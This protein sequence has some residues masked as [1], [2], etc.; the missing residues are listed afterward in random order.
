MIRL[1]A[2]NVNSFI[3][4]RTTLDTDGIIDMH[5]GDR[6]RTNFLGSY[7]CFGV[8]VE[9]TNLFSSIIVAKF[10]APII[11]NNLSALTN[12]IIIG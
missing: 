2:T 4:T 12:Q 3:H 10:T 11:Y 8:Y 7:F 6:K 5:L 1:D 9:E